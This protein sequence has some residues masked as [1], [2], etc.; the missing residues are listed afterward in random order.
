MIYLNATSYIWILKVNFGFPNVSRR[1]QPHRIIKIRHS[2]GHFV[3][4][5]PNHPLHV[6]DYIKYRTIECDKQLY[7]HNRTFQWFLH[8]CNPFLLES[9]L[10]V[11][12]LTIN[13]NGTPPCVVVNL[14]ERSQPWSFQPFYRFT[15][16][17]S[18]IESFK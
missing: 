5:C 8:S 4:F 18:S 12:V 16:A 9:L 17:E 10:V 2:E 15:A 11:W 6:N 7:N 3:F 14:R 13:A 1:Q